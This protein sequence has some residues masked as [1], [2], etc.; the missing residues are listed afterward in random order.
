MTQMVQTAAC[1]KHHSLDQQVCRWLL[2]SLDRLQGTQ[3]QMT[4][5]LIAHMLGVTAE[6]ATEAALKLKALGLIA[7]E[8]ARLQVLGRHAREKRSCECYAAVKQEY[9]RLLP[10]EF[11]A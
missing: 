6:N 1:N 3:M 8:G 7:Y 5:Q 4:R 11:A 2:L 9:D 10:L